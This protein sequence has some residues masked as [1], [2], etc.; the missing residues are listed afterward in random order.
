MSDCD[1]QVLLTTK[2]RFKE[3]DIH[4]CFQRDNITIIVTKTNIEMY[5]FGVLRYKYE[6][7]INYEMILL[8]KLLANC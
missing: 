1:I 5:I 4:N 8:Y 3:T 6:K 7:N 2:Y